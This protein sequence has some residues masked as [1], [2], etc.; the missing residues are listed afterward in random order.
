M[1]RGVYV[2]ADRSRTV[3]EGSPEAAYR[4]HLEEARRLGLLEDDEPKMRRHPPDKAVRRRADK[5]R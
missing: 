3:P 5:S 2:T 1:S 4:I